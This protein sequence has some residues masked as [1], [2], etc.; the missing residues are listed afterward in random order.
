MLFFVGIIIAISGVFLVSNGACFVVSDR[1]VVD[2]ERCTRCC[3]LDGTGR[4]TRCGVLDVVVEIEMVEPRVVFEVDVLLVEM[5]HRGVGNLEEEARRTVSDQGSHSTETYTEGRKFPPFT[6]EQNVQQVE[7]H[8]AIDQVP[9][10]HSVREWVALVETSDSSV[11]DHLPGYR[12]RTD[13]SRTF[14]C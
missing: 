10:M 9:R 2:T 7:L 4:C 11:R 14:Q 5:Q 1:T 8:N 13:T 6:N 3:E 12:L